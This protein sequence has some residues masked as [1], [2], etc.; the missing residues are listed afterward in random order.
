MDMNLR[1]ELRP[2]IING[3]KKGLFHRWEQY[4]EPIAAGRTVGSHPAGQVSYVFGI[5]EIEGG[6]VTRIHPSSIRFIDN[7]M[8]EYCF[9]E[10]AQE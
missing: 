9:T 7:K 5:V 10:E 3:E 1:A 8:A 2:C 6:Y 4:A